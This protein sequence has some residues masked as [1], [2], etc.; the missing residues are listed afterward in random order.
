MVRLC[1]NTI[2]ARSCNESDP[3]KW[4]PATMLGMIEQIRMLIEKQ[5]EA[6][7]KKKRAPRNPQLRRTP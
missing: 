5:E 1:E 6:C 2:A 4:T 7:A 3:K